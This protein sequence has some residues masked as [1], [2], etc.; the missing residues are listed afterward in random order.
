[1]LNGEAVGIIVCGVFKNL[2]GSY[3][4][5]RRDL[6]KI[7][8]SQLRLGNSRDADALVDKAIALKPVA[9]IPERENLCLFAGQSEFFLELLQLFFT[10]FVF[11]SLGKRLVAFFPIILGSRLRLSALGGDDR[12]Y[13]V[14]FK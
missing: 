6:C 5:E 13:K 7:S 4:G 12:L 3:R 8:L 9:E 14:I 2:G 1:M 10:G 11:L